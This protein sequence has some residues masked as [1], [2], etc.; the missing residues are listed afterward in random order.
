MDF[1]H[2]IKIKIINYEDNSKS[3]YINGIVLSKNIADK[4]MK[5][6]I[7]NPK[8]LLVKDSISTDQS[9]GTSLQTLIEQENNWIN[10]I[11]EKLTQVKPN[12][13]IVEK[14]VGYKILDVLR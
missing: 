6:N 2:F 8:I 11:K 7:P 13:I 12:I 14:D 9:E 1:N 5:T 4:R 3:E 10:I